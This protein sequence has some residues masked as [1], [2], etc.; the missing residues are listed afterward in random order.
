MTWL[1]RPALLYFPLVPAYPVEVVDAEVCRRDVGLVRAWA[2]VR[3][4][5][6]VRVR[7]VV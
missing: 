2:R 3:G 6:R 4:R 1:A 5:V 7:R